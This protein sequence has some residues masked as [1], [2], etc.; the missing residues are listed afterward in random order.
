MDDTNDKQTTFPKRLMRHL[1]AFEQQRAAVAKALKV[2]ARF[3]VYTLQ[4]AA[5]HGVL[6]DD[7]FE[8]EKENG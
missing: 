8:S 7:V 5:S 6:N 1:L 2:M 4:G 3:P